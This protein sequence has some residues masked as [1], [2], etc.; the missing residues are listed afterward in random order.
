MFFIGIPNIIK[1]M[2]LML[3]KIKQ[4]SINGKIYYE[5][6]ERLDTC[7]IVLPTEKKTV[8]YKL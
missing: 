6:K 3:D 8:E 7:S 1:G 4:L 2:G 5:K